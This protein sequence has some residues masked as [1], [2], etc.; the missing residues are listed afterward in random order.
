MGS[1]IDKYI[2]AKYKKY[3][4]EEL[5][6]RIG[7]PEGLVRRYKMKLRADGYLMPLAIEPTA[8][9]V[10]KLT[11]MS[12]NSSKPLIQIMAINKLQDLKKE[13]GL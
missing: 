10:E 7:I 2:I 8:E 13:F 6:K 9:L 5:A 4:N 11:E 1:V 12:L 3:T